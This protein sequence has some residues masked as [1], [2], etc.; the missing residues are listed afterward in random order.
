MKLRIHWHQKEH[1]ALKP[2]LLEAFLQALQ[3]LKI[4]LNIQDQ[5]AEDGVHTVDSKDFWESNI[6]LHEYSRRR[7]LAMTVRLVD[8][9][10]PPLQPHKGQPSCLFLGLRLPPMQ[11]HRDLVVGA[12]K[13]GASSLST[14][15]KESAL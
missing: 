1:G 9:G 8:Y 13:V 6:S 3:A 14:F 10:L 12:E 11:H 7:N 5:L 2:A 15:P 4:L